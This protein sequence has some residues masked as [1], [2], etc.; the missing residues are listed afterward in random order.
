MSTSS[1]EPAILDNRAK[2]SKERL[3]ELRRIKADLISKMPTMA[4]IIA[5]RERC[6][7]ERNYDP[8]Q[9]H[10][11]E[12]RAELSAAVSAAVQA[13]QRP[14]DNYQTWL[15]SLTEAE[16]VAMSEWTDEGARIDFDCCRD[17]LCS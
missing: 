6:M 2:P 12:E 16:C 15:K 11:E 9:H 13:T 3:A 7:Q 8:D 4:K 10:T 17:G 14:E 1:N 5:I